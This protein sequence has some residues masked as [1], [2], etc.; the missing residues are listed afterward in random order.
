MLF[1]VID[2]NPSQ[3]M[4]HIIAIKDAPH[5][6]M[7]PSNWL[8]VCRSCHEILEGNVIDG[9]KVKRWSEEHY[10]RELRSEEHGC[11]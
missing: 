7:D 3:D 9:L 8:A 2:A 10:H 6:R 11:V 4:H 1:S 5:A